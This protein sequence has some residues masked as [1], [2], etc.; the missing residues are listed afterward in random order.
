MITLLEHFSQLIFL[1][2]NFFLVKNR[3]FGQFSQNAETL[4]I[5][6]FLKMPIAETLDTIDFSPFLTLKPLGE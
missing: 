4:G 1:T 5:T 2:N 6:D 3:V